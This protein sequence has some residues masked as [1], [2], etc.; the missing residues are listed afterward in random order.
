MVTIKTNKGDIKLELFE[1]DAPETVK[2]FLTYVAEGF[3]K[4]TLFQVF[5]LLPVS[6]S[7]RDCHTN[8]NNDH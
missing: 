4:N 1:K 5:S 2:N 7:F 6:P 3:Y 8:R